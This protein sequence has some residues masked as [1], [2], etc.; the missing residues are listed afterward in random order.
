M[1]NEIAGPTLVEEAYGFNPVYTLDISDQHVCIKWAGGE[2]WLDMSEQSDHFCIDVRQLRAP[3]ME[4]NESTPL[5]PAPQMKGQG[6]FTIVN[7]RRQS[8]G[9]AHG[10]DFE[11]KAQRIKDEPLKGKNGLPVTGHG[12]NGGYVITLL[13]DRHG[14]ELAIAPANS[15]GNG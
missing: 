5:A 2:V 12:W 4:F 3:L 1:S 6:A 14:E 9:E 7:G 13:T 8:L 11:G 10:I 15:Q